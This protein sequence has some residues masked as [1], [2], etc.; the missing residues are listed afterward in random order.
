MTDEVF[1]FKL[2]ILGRETMKTKYGKIKCLKIRPYV[3]A[4]RVFKE[5]ESVTM[6][7]TDDENH[8]PVQIK[9]ELAV[10]SLKVDLHDYKNVKYPLNFTK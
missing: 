4:G 9:A 2:M 8:I 3:Q 7:V 1:K 10:G 5:S 6:W